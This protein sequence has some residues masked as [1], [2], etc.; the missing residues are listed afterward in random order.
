MPRRN[1]RTRTNHES[2]RTRGE[3]RDRSKRKGRSNGRRKLRGT[4]VPRS[5]RDWKKDVE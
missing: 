5:R 1:Q 2:D 4:D 3:R